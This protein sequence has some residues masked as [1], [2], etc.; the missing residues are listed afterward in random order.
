[1]NHDSGI[2]RVIISGFAEDKIK[3]LPKA[4]SKPDHARQRTFILIKKYAIQ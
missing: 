2:A 3:V 1:M 4:K